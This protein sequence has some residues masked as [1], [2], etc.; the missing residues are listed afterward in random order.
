MSALGELRSAVA[1]LEAVVAGLEPACVSGADAAVLVEQFAKAKR[2]C[3]AG[4]ALAAGRVAQ[5][6]AW[7]PSGERSAASALAKSAVPCAMTLRP[8]RNFN[9]AGLGV[10]SVSMNMGAS[11]G[12]PRAKGRPIATLLPEDGRCPDPV[13]PQNKSGL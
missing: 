5:S 6:G 13:Q 3:A 10:C 11:N 8:G 4:E 2:L 1:T 9:V 7:R 12:P